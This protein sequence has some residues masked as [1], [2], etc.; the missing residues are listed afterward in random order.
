MFAPRQQVGV[1]N[2]FQSFANL[3]LRDLYYRRSH[4]KNHFSE[5]AAAVLALHTFALANQRF[6][7][8]TARREAFVGLRCLR[9][10]LDEFQ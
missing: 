8:F 5:A 3:V 2:R 1:A 7:H 6:E 4:S 10:L 9:L